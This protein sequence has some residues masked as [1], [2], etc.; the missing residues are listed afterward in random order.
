ML[1]NSLMNLPGV[2]KDLLTEIG[3]ISG[4]SLE[5][6]PQELSWEEFYTLSRTYH[7]LTM[8]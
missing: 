6:R 3:L 7:R 1:K 5:K 2:T 8:T 4:I